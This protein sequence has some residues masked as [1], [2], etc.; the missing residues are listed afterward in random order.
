MWRGRQKY[1]WGFMNVTIELQKAV[2][3]G[4]KCI[5]SFTFSAVLTGNLLAREE[6]GMGT[7]KGIQVCGLFQMKA[8]ICRGNCVLRS[9]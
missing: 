4:Q 3:F 7:K 6:A 8:A 9:K 2:E 5:F 1:S